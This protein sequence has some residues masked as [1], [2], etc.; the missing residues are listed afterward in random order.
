MYLL[1]R[2][3]PWTSI[4]EDIRTILIARSLAI[5]RNNNQSDKE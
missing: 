2:H 5:P 1:T 4:V 3:F